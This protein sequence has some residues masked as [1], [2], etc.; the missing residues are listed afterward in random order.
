MTQIKQILIDRE[1]LENLRD[2]TL[3]CLSD[4]NQLAGTS[5][6][7]DLT[8]KSFQDDL[9]RADLLLDMP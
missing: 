1:L 7:N 3:L 5:N 2:N 4:A 6:R 9:E 8:I